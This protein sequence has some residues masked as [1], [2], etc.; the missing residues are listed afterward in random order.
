MSMANVGMLINTTVYTENHLAE[1][2]LSALI[3]NKLQILKVKKNN[4]YRN[5]GKIF[6]FDLHGGS[7]GVMSAMQIID[8][9]IQSGQI[10]NG[11][12]IAGDT[13]PRAGHTLN[14]NYEDNAGAILLSNDPRIKGFE[15]F[16]TY[17]YPEFESSVISSITWGSGK[18]RFVISQSENYLK[19]CLKCV[20]ISL[21]QFFMKTNSGWDQVDL[22]VT[23]QSPPGFSSLL[24]KKFDLE[25]KILPINGKSEI[26]TAGVVFSLKK[27]FTNGKFKAATNILFVTVSSGI[28]VSLSLYLNQ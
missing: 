21:Q 8:G 7:T 10:E 19:D 27:V 18:F 6:S 4:K 5:S 11:L 1:P 25:G 3:L 23:S 13:K 9:F 20:E 26:F 24:M 14:Y 16:K 17:T 28:T 15:K 12:I 22:I 2:A